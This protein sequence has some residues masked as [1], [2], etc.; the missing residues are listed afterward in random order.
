VREGRRREKKRKN[1][2]FFSFFFSFAFFEGRRRT[3]TFPQSSPSLSFIFLYTQ[4][5]QKGALNEYDEFF[6]LSRREFVPPNFA[7]LR[8]VLNIAQ[9]HASAAA[10]LRLVTFDADGTLYAD[11][12]HMQHDNEMIA[13]IIRLLQLGVDVAIVT[14]AGY[15]GD[16]ARFEQR[17][18]GL[19]AAFAARKLPRS[20]TDRFHIMGGECNYLLRAVP[21]PGFRSS[22]SS[23]SAGTGASSSPSS[24][25]SSFSAAF[26]AAS[27]SSNGSV[28]SASSLPSAPYYYSEDEEGGSSENEASTSSHASSS[29]GRRRGASSSTSSRSDLDFFAASSSDDEGNDGNEE[30][31][32]AARRRRRRRRHLHHASITAEAASAS[33]DANNNAAA[34]AA[35]EEEEEAGEE[36]AKRALSAAATARAVAASPSTQLPSHS[37]H[38][39]RLAFVPDGEW[40]SPEMASWTHEEIER[41]LDAAQEALEEGAARLRLPVR[42]IRKERA[43]G[44]LPLAPTVYEVL[45]DLAI[46]VQVE[47]AGGKRWEGET[48]KSNRGR[49]RESDDENDG[50]NSNKGNSSSNSNSNSPLL[51]FC[52]FNGGGDVFVDVGNKS[53]GLDALKA[54]LGLSPSQV[55]HVGDRFTA[56]GNDSATRDCCSILWVANPEET[57]FFIKLLIADLEDQQA[58]AGFGGASP[59]SPPSPPPSP[60]GLLGRVG[61]GE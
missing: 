26:A 49:R 61:E 48:D 24:S 14:A 51:P 34:A 11:G 30:D 17:V 52:A 57:D 59:S 10:G 45:E 12:A 31:S 16:A 53:L 4:P 18:H 36:Q 40:K 20:V 47:L 39:H 54:Y 28:S 33:S 42:V 19:L 60:S 46:S 55:L 5:N 32:T 15:P 7:E 56:S 43:V 8:H 58:A 25:S 29:F 41:L 23:S 3:K 22:N 13:L 6:A 1:S 37:P 35:E 44:V 9:V 50:N 27:S 21:P 38:S 2:G